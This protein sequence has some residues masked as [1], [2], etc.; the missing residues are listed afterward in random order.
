[1]KYAIG[2]DAGGTNFRIGIVD[3]TGKIIS[4][5]KFQT[6]KDT[7][8]FL[9]AT[10]EST[11]EILS[12][13]GLD[14][15]KDIKGVGIA[16]ASPLNPETGEV[17]WTGRFP[18]PKDFNIKEE[19]SERLGK[20]VFI[21]NDMNVA[22]E[23]EAEFGALRGVKNGVVITVST[24]IG[25]GF[26]LDGK[27]YQ[28]HNFAS[29]EVGHMIVDPQSKEFKCTHGHTGDWEALGAATSAEDR[30]EKKYGKRITAKEIT[31]KAKA[32]DKDCRE[33]LKETA[34]W[35]GIGLVNIV[36]LMD[37]EVIVIFSGFFNGLWE[38]FSGDIKKILKEKSLNPN[39]KFE[40]TQLGDN[41]GLLGAAS[42]VF[43]A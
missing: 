1:M 19:L 17:K 15:N 7:D 5:K 3:S 2:I 38:M 30:Y 11:K 36:N 32:G 26:L 34:H 14:T 18:F 43:R 25:G 23:G 20:P 27:V 35:A 28:G 41:G 12:E 31:E 8:S 21:G 24:G 33:I 10:S 42:L 40:P 39:V 22:T 13:A 29:A 16:I 37:P 6:P 9:K 4:Q